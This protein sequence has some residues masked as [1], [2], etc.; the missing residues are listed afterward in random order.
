MLIRHCHIQNEL[1]VAAASLHVAR[2]AAVAITL[3]PARRGAA[4]LVETRRDA[5][6]SAGAPEAVL[7]SSIAAIV[8]DCALF[9]PVRL[10]CTTSVFMDFLLKLLYLLLYPAT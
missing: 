3:D 6:V 5:L 10:R 2:I 1:A 9:V 4:R 7:Y 8:A